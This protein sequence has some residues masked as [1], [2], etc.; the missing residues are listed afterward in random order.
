MQSDIIPVGPYEANCCLLWK[1]PAKAWV[2]DPGA[3]GRMILDGLAMNNLSCGVILLT[4]GH[5]DHVGSVG[6]IL[7]A[8]PD[9]P[10]YIHELDAAF[11]FSPVNVQP[12]Y[13]DRVTAKPKTLRTDLGDG[14]TLTV[15]GLTARFVH[16]PGHTP[17]GMCFWFLAD[18]V[19]LSGD[20]LFAG[21]CGR[22]DFPG[23]SWN[24]MAQSL[25]KLKTMI[26]DDTRVICGHGPET[27][28]REEKLHNQYLAD[29]A[30]I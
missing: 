11:A 15:G 6:E 2:V 19:L 29:E 4:H 17:G 7:A 5:F 16:T 24:E 23:G 3:D 28:M 18:K 9:A 14:A 20:T 8:F 10:V 27:T 30:E 12:P 1:D 13:Y 22:T 26:P 25:R 21:S